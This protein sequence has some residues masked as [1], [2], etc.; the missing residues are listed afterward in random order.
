MV[1][2]QTGEQN[3]DEDGSGFDVAAMVRPQ[4]GVMVS[5]SWCH[6]LCHTAI[7][8]REAQCVEMIE[9]GR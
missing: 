7:V 4:C 1:S 5:S 6:E 9:E 2:E 8:R 3:Y